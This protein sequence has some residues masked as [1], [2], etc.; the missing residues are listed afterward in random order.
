MSTPTASEHEITLNERDV[1][2]L[3][4]L[5]EAGYEPAAIEH[6]SEDDR[7]RARRLLAL[8]NLLD[9]D[10]VVEGEDF[11]DETLIHATLARIDQYE[12][13]QAERMRI[14]S[15]D[16]RRFSFRMGDLVGVAAALLLCVGLI[17]PSL[18]SNQTPSPVGVSGSATAGASPVFGQWLRASLS[19]DDAAVSTDNMAAGASLEN[20]VAATVD[21]LREAL[22]P[23]SSLN[24]DHEYWFNANPWAVP[25]DHARLIRVPA[26]L[27]G[28]AEDRYFLLAPVYGPGESEGSTTRM[29][30]ILRPVRI[31]G[32]LPPALNR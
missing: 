10:P 5:A 13:R 26:E 15:G 29:G 1:A 27:A 4:A 8:L 3:D 23:L 17:W 24:A 28:S 21:Q 22:P 9:Q 12:A 20:A 16:N 30:W 11:R 31:T 2:V 25:G 18:R 32:E 19:D 6:L 14:G 7:V